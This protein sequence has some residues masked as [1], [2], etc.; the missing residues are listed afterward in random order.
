MPI[1]LPPHLR[2]QNIFK[3]ARFID[4]SHVEKSDLGFLVHFWLNIV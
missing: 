2:G 1:N 4:K 3:N